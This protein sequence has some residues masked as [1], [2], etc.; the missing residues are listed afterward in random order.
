MKC[1]DSDVLCVPLECLDARLVLIVPDLNMSMGEEETIAKLAVL[2]LMLSCHRL[3]IQ[4][5]ISAYTVPKVN[6]D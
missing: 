4:C 6:K 3:I 1:H 2:S 5:P